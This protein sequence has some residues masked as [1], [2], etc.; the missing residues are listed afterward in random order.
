M[1]DPTIASVL[2]NCVVKC[3]C[4][5][6]LLTAIAYQGLSGFT[7]IR[8]YQVLPFQYAANNTC[9]LV[10]HRDDLLA[11][12]TCVARFWTL[13][14]KMSPKRRGASQPPNG[15]AAKITRRTQ[16][17]TTDTPVRGRRRSA[18]A[19]ATATRP[20]D[21]S[22]DTT[23]DAIATCRALAPRAIWSPPARELARR[24]CTGNPHSPAFIL[25]IIS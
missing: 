7:V 23:A 13:R 8:C 10:Y 25:D 6:R 1:V 22:A 16:Q 18:T 21:K 11:L 2:V 4:C 19:T 5:S 9:D 20:G 14:L 3:C 15:R 24:R 12:T 17:R